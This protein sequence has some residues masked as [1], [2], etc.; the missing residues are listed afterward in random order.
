[1]KKLLALAI[2][3]AIMFSLTACG[4]VEELTENKTDRTYTIHFNANGGE[5]KMDDY[6]VESGDSGW[7]PKCTFTK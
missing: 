3:I 6:L 7:L 2:T 4:F 5:G 1:M